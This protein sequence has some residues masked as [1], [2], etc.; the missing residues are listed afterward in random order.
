MYGFEEEGINYIEN[1]ERAKDTIK[2]YVKTKS[3]KFR[4]EFRKS[5]YS[6]LKAVAAKEDDEEPK[7]DDETESDRRNL[8]Y[9]G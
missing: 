8:F 1:F 3:K 2:K 4:E 5:V 6:E 9:R 7:L